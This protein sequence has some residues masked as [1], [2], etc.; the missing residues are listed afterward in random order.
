MASNV[1]E[2]TEKER[3]YRIGPSERAAEAVLAAVSAVSERDVE[4]ISGGEDAS[5]R[6]SPLYRSVDPDAL[7]ALFRPT[8]GSLRGDGRVTFSYAGCEVTVRADGVVRVRPNRDGE[9]EDD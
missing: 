8:A 3:T 7:D 1:G 4:S 9:A 2:P 6:V 5:S